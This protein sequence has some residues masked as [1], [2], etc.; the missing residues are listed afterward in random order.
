MRYLVLFILCQLCIP[1]AVKLYAQEPLKITGYIYTTDKLPISNATVNLSKSQKRTISDRNGHFSVS[2]SHPT[3]TLVITSVGYNKKIILVNTKS[4]MPLRIFLENDTQLL[5]EVSVST[6][7]Q[8]LSKERATGAFYKIGNKLFNQNISTDV[9]SRLEGIS[10][11]MLFDNRNPNE[12]KIQIRGLSTLSIESQP[13]IILDNFPYE[14]DI[15]NIN[16]N[17]VENVTILKDAASASIWGARAGNG[18]IVITT[19]KGKTFF[20]LLN[21]ER[22]ARSREEETMPFVLRT[23]PPER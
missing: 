10:S 18:V 14:C 22:W 5:Q 20:S 4:F 6:G 1:P 2:A 17:D 8:T 9:I 19:K 13:L 23:S 16:P 21:E 3:D 11:G 15:N 7:Y 12:T